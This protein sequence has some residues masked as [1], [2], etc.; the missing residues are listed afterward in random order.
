MLQKT[1]GVVLGYIKY[2]DTSII[3]KI[4]TEEF[5]LQTYI[6][7]GVRSKSS[8][9]KIAMFQSLTLLDM[10]VYHKE[11]REINRI[12]EIK[13]NTVFHSIPFEQ[14]KISI[15]VFLAELLGKTLKEH[16]HNKELFELIIHTIAYLDE[17]QEHYENLH[18]QFMIQ[19]ASFLGFSPGSVDELM[20]EILISLS[21]EEKNALAQLMVVSPDQYVRMNN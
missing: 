13:C 18:L 3:S 2:G 19:L 8:K 16:Y 14:K 12:S 20:Q 4:Y 10:V 21:E 1:R 9:N 5:G 11:N 6:V 15:V 7:N 17:V